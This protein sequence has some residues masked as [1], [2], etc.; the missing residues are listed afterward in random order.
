M[1]CLLKIAKVYCES[2]WIPAVV[3]V[4]SFYGL[5]SILYYSNETLKVVPEVL[6][7]T[8]LCMIYLTIVV[9]FAMMLVSVIVNMCKRRWW[10]GVVAC[11]FCIAGSVPIAIFLLVAMMFSKWNG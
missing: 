5:G 1:K 10:R 9:T 11:L 6:R 8:I 2:C 3:H 7:Q 4:A